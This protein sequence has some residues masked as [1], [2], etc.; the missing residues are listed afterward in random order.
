M[1]HLCH[2]AVV[3]EV[4]AQALRQVRCQ[5]GRLDERHQQ[6]GE[7]RVRSER[8]RQRLPF[9]Q[10]PH[11]AADHG[12][13]AARGTARLRVE[14]FDDAEPRDEQVVQLLDEHRNIELVSSGPQRQVQAQTRALRAHRQNRVPLP[15]RQGLGLARRGR[16]QLEP[17]G[18]VTPARDA[19]LVPHGLAWR[20]GAD[21][22]AQRPDAQ[23]LM[24]AS[25]PEPPTCPSRPSVSTS[26]SRPA[27]PGL[28]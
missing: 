21:A 28:L 27:S 2:A 5:L 8:G 13:R 16:L 20:E 15:N 3:F 14:R 9:A 24:S 1:A 10:P 18:G 7:H 4:A 19:E 6:L 22:P 11:H 17:L 26:N 23:T 25:S 12:H